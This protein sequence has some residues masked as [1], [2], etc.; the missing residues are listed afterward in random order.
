MSKGKGNQEY[1]YKAMYEQEVIAR[2]EACQD[3]DAVQEYVSDL[4]DTNDSLVEALAAYK[5]TKDEQSS[6]SN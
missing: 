1:Y 4:E 6:T 2:K 5:R 3:L